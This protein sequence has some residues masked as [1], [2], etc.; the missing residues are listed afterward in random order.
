MIFRN[1]GGWGVKGRLEHFRKFIP[2]GGTN[3]RSPLTLFPLVLR[4]V[5]NVKLSV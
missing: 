1:E 2:V 3:R 5:L 4:L